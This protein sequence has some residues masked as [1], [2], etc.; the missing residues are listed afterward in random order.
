MAWNETPVLD[1]LASMT[2]EPLATSA[3]DAIDVAEIEEE[4]N[5]GAGR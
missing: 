5:A 4:R 3:N 2:A 1:L